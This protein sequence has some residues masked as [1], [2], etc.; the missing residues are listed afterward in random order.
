MKNIILILFVVF[1]CSIESNSEDSLTLD[2]NNPELIQ[3]LNNHVG[4]TVEEFL[5]NFCEKGVF[6]KSYMYSTEPPG[7]LRGCF[8][9]YTD[10]FNIE[11]TIKKFDYIKNTYIANE[12]WDFNQFKKEI[13]WYFGVSDA[14]QNDIENS[15]IT[16]PYGMKNWKMLN[17]EEI[18]KLF[19]KK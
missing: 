4:K 2:I 7:Y 12:D 10:E 17:D 14:Q 18:R 3:F 16:I 6:Y 13:I 15:Y 19:K 1:F 8:F 9:I 11:V 5:K